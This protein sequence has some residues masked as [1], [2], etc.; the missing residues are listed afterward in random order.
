MA[1]TIAKKAAFE[2]KSSPLLAEFVA[3][4][5]IDRACR[6]WAVERL[7]GEAEQWRRLGCDAEAAALRALKRTIE[8]EASDG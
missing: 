8:Q 4:N 5:I 7:A 6:A 3:A 1:S 2:I